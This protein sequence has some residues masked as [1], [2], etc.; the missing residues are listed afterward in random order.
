MDKW[1]DGMYRWTADHPA[2]KCGMAPYYVSAYIFFNLSYNL[3][4]IALLKF[5]SA[6]LLY[7]AVRGRGGER[8]DGWLDGWMDRWMD[9]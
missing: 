1:M 8:I 7:I 9:G 4:I 6:A 3:L 2:D 5:G